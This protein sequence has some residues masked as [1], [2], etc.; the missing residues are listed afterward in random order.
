MATKNATLRNKMA[1]DFAALW[2]EATLVIKDSGDVT[3]VTFEFGNPAFG[4]ASNG[5]VS[6]TG[7]PI[8]AIAAA[9]GT[10]AKA[11]LISDGGTYTITDLTVGLSA[12]QVI[13]DNLS[14]NSGQT[15]N[16]TA[17]S[18]TESASV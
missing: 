2:D 8:S 4:S 1:T 18:W 11:E 12:S 9:T 5:T 14:I 3:L 13:L 17:F 6:L 16:L 10:A 7:L 15:V